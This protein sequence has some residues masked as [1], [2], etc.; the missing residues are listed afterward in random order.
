MKN[1]CTIVAS[2]LSHR[3]SLINFGNRRVSVS[4][5]V[6]NDREWDRRGQ[7]ITRASVINRSKEGLCATLDGTEDNEERGGQG[8]CVSV[9]GISRW[10]NIL[11]PRGEILVDDNSRTRGAHLLRRPFLF[12]SRSRPTHAPALGRNFRITP[13]TLSRYRPL[14]STLLWSPFLLEK[15]VATFVLVLTFPETNVLWTAYPLPHIGSP[16]F[17]VRERVQNLATIDPRFETWELILKYAS[18]RRRHGTRNWLA[19]SY[20]GGG[21]FLCSFFFRRSTEAIFPC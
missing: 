18:K 1:R 2:F 19:R 5:V 21:F 6:D 16:T 9:A 7:A 4:Q 8:A 12:Q 20:L 13:T 15:D 10:K 14:P 17:H 3:N 11:T